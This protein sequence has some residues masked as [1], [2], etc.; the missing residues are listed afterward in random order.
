MLHTFNSAEFEIKAKGDRKGVDSKRNQRCWKMVGL[1][2]STQDE[3]SQE[4]RNRVGDRNGL[5]TCSC[6]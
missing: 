6:S 1:P 4:M 3:D 2:K 5:S